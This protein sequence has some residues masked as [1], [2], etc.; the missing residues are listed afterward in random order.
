MGIELAALMRDGVF[1]GEGLTDGRGQPVLLIP[2]FMAGDGS[3]GVMARWL[4][5]TGHHP[6]RAGIRANVACSAKSLDR[7]E[8]RLESLVERQGRRAAIVGHSRGG[9]F[10]KCLAVRRPDLVSGVVALGSPNL[11][12]L[13]VHPLVRANVR[14][15]ATLGRLGVPGLFSSACLAGDCCDEFW[16]QCASPMPPGMGYVSVYSRTD[17]VVE[18]RACLDEG[19]EHVEVRS[20][21]CGMAVNAGTYRA[22]AEALEGFRRRD[23]RRRRPARAGRPALRVA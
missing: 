4:K 20:S 19:A 2:G 21:H 1:R 5:G 17:G 22:V 3:L 15:V 10:A 8:Q 18:W 7:L 9:G 23:A 16:V 13:D 6:S 14:A 11:G 12:P